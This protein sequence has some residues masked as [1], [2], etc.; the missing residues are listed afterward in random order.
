VT[1]DIRPTR[2][3]KIA[4][5]SVTVTLEKLLS[6]E[7]PIE[8]R[9]TG[10]LPISYEAGDAVLD[11]DTALVIGPESKVSQVVKVIATVDLTNVT[12]SIDRSIDLKPLDSRG[13]IVTGV[14]LNPTQVNVEIPIRQLG[15]YRNVFVKIV[16][17]G[18]VAQGFYLTG[19]TVNPPTI[20]I[21]STDPALAANMPS[22]IETVPLRLNG[23][24]LSFESVVALNLPEGINVVGDQNVT[25]SVGVAPIQSSIQL[26][27]VPVEAVNVASGLEVTLSPDTVNLYL[28]G[29]LYL[30]EQLNAANI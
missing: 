3:E 25:V 19:I 30:L 27:D 5:E 15:G 20:T 22:Y 26:V 2:V 21:Y 9:Q 6:R 16:T 7:F 28:S 13:V 12:T 11:V 10:S 24:K 29:P 14:S 23:G 1:I 18:Q 4:P 8:L 17:T